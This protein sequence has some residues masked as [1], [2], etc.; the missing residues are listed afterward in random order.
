M[1]WVR[2]TLRIYRRAVLDRTG[3]AR[4][5][6]YRHGYIRSYCDFKRWLERIE[7]QHHTGP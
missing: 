1:E 3:F 6:H 2:R 4:T 7:A 5:G